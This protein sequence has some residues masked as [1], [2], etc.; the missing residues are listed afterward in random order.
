MLGLQMPSR[1]PPLP[2]CWVRPYVE[3]MKWRERIEKVECGLRR[4]LGRVLSQCVGCDLGVLVEE[5]MV[6]AVGEVVRLVEQ[7]EAGVMKH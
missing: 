6:R 4:E 1:R 7:R 3:G 2:S 5:V